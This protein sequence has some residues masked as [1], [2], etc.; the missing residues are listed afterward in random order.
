MPILSSE[1]IM[2]NLKKVDNW[3]FDTN[4]I[5]SEYQFKDLKKRLDLLIKLAMKL[6]K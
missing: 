6:R 1:E 4:Q 2:Q 5:H 3:S